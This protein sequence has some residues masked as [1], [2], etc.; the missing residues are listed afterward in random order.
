MLNMKKHFWIIGLPIYILII[1][2]PFILFY[3]NPYYFLGGLEKLRRDREK[4]YSAVRVKKF[5]DVK[6]H[7]EESLQFYKD[8]EAGIHPIPLYSKF[9]SNEEIKEHGLYVVGHILQIDE[10]ENQK[11]DQNE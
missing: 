7:T 3:N 8:L 4:P 9:P 11:K 1:N 10:G 5:D 2:S 6:V